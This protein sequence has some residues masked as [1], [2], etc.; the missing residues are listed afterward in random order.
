MRA[1]ADGPGVQDGMRY[2]AHY[3]GIKMRKII[4]IAVRPYNYVKRKLSQIMRQQDINAYVRSGRKPWSRGYNISKFDFIADALENADIMRRFQDLSSL[5][6]GY[7]TRYDERVVEYPWALAR[8]SAMAGN[9]LDAGSVLNFKEIVEN[10]ILSNKK[11]T[12]FTLVPENSAFWQKGISYDYGDLRDLPYRDNRFDEICSLSTLGHVGMD[13][14]IYTKTASAGKI[15]LEAER[16]V[17][18]L[19]RVLKPGGRLLVS[20]VFGKHQLIEW[21]GAPFAEQFDSHLLN[22]LLRSFSPCSKVSTSFYKYSADGW[23]ISKEEECKDAEYFNIH[24]SDSCDPDYAAAARAV[25][26]IEAIK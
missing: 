24:V 6:P 16:A 17:K 13:N 19:I 12:I 25:A 26:L 9:L 18:E 1:P 5:P 14:R 10:K 21:D 4:S 20:V 11:I 22:D 7:G 23:N 3:Q 8:L 2:G 15:G